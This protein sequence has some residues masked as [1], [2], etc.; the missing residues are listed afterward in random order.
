MNDR[1]AFLKLMAAAVAAA[2]PA[3]AGM[4]RS[5]QASGERSSADR[6]DSQVHAYFAAAQGPALSRAVRA[7][8][9]GRLR[10]HRDANRREG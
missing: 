5:G 7:R 3:F 9:R 6:P 8:A 1:R 2:T 4:R 10:R